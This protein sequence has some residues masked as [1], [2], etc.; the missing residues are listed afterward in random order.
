MGF[1]GARRFLSRDQNFSEGVAFAAAI[2]RKE[3]PMKP[4]IAVLTLALAALSPLVSATPAEACAMRK[5]AAP[6][7]GEEY[8]AQGIAAEARGELHTAIRHY[9]RA[10]NASKGV[11]QADAAVRAARLHHKLGAS[12]RAINRLNRAV[13]AA[14][15]FLE[16]RVLLGR[17]LT[18]SNPAE[19]IPHFEVAL[20]LG[21]TGDLHAEMALAA[22]RAGRAELARTHLD[23]ARQHGAA[24]EHILAAE[25]ALGV[26]VAVL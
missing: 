24:V 9:E 22:A 16:A 19:A 2:T 21:A 12:D 26:G 23:L 15:R 5:I 8:V 13:A 20:Q 1:V 11:A 14:P 6:I 7:A 10:M 4:A 25:E 17:A 18:A 3:P